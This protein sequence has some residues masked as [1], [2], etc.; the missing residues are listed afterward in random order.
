MNIIYIAVFGIITVLLA[1]LFK[2]GK[3]EYATYISVAACIIIF[4]FS[5]SKL[6]IIVNTINVIQSYITISQSYI[7]ALL[8][9]IGITY[10]AEFSSDICKDTGHSAIANQIQIFGKL[11]VLAVSMPII[12][13]LLETIDSLLT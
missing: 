11:S 5:I 12:L 2:S 4:F 13:A 10:I 1:V 8:K 6:D 9:I 7:T 3:N